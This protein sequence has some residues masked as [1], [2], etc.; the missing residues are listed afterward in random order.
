M[1][2]ARKMNVL[3]P[4]NGTNQQQERG[5]DMIETK[6]KTVAAVNP[7]NDDLLID[8]RELAKWLGL[9]PRTI[10][11]WRWR[12]VGPE[13]TKPGRYVRYRKGDVRQWLEGRK[14]K[15]TAQYSK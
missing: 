2:K 8:N 14:F 12:G 13:F 11:M 10:D 4:F 6:M 5:K 9:S 7:D 1:R 3:N 15:N